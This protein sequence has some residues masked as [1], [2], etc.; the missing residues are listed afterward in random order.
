MTVFHTLGLSYNIVTRNTKFLELIV[1]MIILDFYTLSKEYVISVSERFVL[2]RTMSLFTVIVSPFLV[3]SIGL[4][5]VD[6]TLRHKYF[7]HTP[8]VLRYLNLLV[9][10][11]PKI[12]FSDVF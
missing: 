6:D 3:S 1:L 11:T 12:F 7:P 10:L 5:S 9:M 4:L 8:L 2:R